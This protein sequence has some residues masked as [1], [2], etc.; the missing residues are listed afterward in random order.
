MN[1]TI[2][3]IISE[4]YNFMCMRETNSSPKDIR[5]QQRKDTT[6]IYIDVEYPHAIARHHF[7]VIYLENP[8]SQN[9]AIENPA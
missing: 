6:H 3:S 5:I 1:I 9:M 7:R 2:N 8:G 4:C